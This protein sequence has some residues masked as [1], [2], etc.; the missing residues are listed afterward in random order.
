M[1][2]CVSAE[3]LSAASESVCRACASSP[4]ATIL[5]ST[6]PWRAIAQDAPAVPAI[7]VRG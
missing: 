1:S 5:P 6:G 7:A 3:S 2:A 4:D